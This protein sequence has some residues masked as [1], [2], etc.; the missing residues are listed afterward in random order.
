MRRVVFEAA[1]VRGVVGGRNHDTVGQ[2]ALAISIVGQDGVR[3]D[4]RRR[5]SVIASDP[6][7]DPIGSQNLQ[8]RHLGGGGQ[9]MGITA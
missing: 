1:V 5:V 2:T 7:F 8:C 3:D 4:G 6:D 9:G